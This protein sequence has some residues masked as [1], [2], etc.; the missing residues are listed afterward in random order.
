M[1]IYLDNCSYNR[2]FDKQLDIIVRLEAEAK[3]Y[4]Q[5]MVKENRIDL[6]WS[7]VNEYENNDNPFDEKRERIGTWK[8]MAV[9]QCVMNES[10][11]LKADE[12]MG[13]KLRAK[14]ALHIASSIYSKCDYFITTDKKILNKNIADIAVVNPITFVEEYTN[15]K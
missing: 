4:I 3:L 14:D 2:P 7:S 11:L 1:R 12:L 5:E 10:I 6:V 8:D 9:E 13:R 15:E